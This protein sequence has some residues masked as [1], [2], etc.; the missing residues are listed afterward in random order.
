MNT[1]RQNQPN[2]TP[3][4]TVAEVATYLQ[5]SIRTVRRLIASG[6]LE[7]VRIGRAVRVSEEALNTLLTQ[8]DKP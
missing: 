7:V 5:V 3:L 1:P 2:L 8:D 4:L 6:E